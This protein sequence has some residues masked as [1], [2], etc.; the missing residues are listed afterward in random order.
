MDMMTKPHLRSVFLAL[1][2]EALVPQLLLVVGDLDLAAD[3]VSQVHGA[4][5][6]VRGLEGAVRLDQGVKILPVLG[7]DLLELLA[8]LVVVDDVLVE[9]VQPHELLVQRLG[10]LRGSLEVPDLL[11]QLNLRVVIS[12]NLP[13]RYFTQTRNVMRDGKYICILKVFRIIV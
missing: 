13:N 2:G 1:G 12:E 9:A 5:Q 10:D 6:P 11:G 7:D 3:V 8:D 4:H